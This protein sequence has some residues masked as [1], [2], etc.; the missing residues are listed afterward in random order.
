MPGTE[1]ARPGHSARLRVPL[2]A[3]TTRSV[4]AACKARG[5]NATYGAD[6]SR[7]YDAGEGEMVGVAEVTAPFARRIV[8]L[9]QMP[10]PEGLPPQN[11]PHL[12][13][14]GVVGTY[15][16]REYPVDGAEGTELAVEDV[17]LGGEMITPAVCC[18]V[19]AWRDTLTLAGVFNTAFYEES[20][21]ME[22]IESVRENLL[23]GLGL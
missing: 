8:P 9:L 2:D 23:K 16:R 14:I 13:S 1:K 21:V 19:W 11:A 4:V 18:H 5:L 10:L 20:F 3:A 7:L 12:S 17:W 6:M 22:V 15:L